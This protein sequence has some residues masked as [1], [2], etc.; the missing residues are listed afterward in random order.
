MKSR[1][2]LEV[3]PEQK[4][5]LQEKAKELNLSLKDYL[6]LKGLDKLK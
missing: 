5:E 4:K 2:I 6:V 3:L 1:I